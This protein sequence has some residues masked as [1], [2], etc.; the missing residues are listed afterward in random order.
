[1]STAH[2]QSR[3]TMPCFRNALKG[4]STGLDCMPILRPRPLLYIGRSWNSGVWAGERVGVDKGLVSERQLLVCCCARLRQEGG[5]GSGSH[6]EGILLAERSIPIP[7]CKFTVSLTYRTI[8]KCGWGTKLTRYYPVL[9]HA[10]TGVTGSCVSRLPLFSRE[11]E[12]L[13]SAGW[14]AAVSLRAAFLCCCG[15]TIS[16]RECLP[17]AGDQVA[18]FDAS[19]QHASRPPARRAK[20]DTHP[21]AKVFRAAY[22]VSLPSPPPLRYSLP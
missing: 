5:P 15:L 18:P 3:R 12:S 8:K 6:R 21:I 2:D 4:I 14:C 19:D 7:K 11:P 16:R 1:M 13:T 9:K 17:S 22:P 20:Q 10:C